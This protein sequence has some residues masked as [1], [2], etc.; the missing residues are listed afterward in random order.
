VVMTSIETTRSCFGPHPSPS[1]RGAGG[2]VISLVKPEIM[3]SLAGIWIILFG[4]S[5]MAMAQ[6]NQNPGPQLYPVS[7]SLLQLKSI[8]HWKMETGWKIYSR[9]TDMVYDAGNHLIG[10]ATQLRSDNTWK[11]YRQYTAAWDGN[12]RLTYELNQI[13]QGAVTLENYKQRLISYD[14]THNSKQEIFQIWSNGV[15]YNQ[16]QITTTYD[17]NQ[18]PAGEIHQSWDGYWVN[19]WKYTRTYDVNNHMTAE[20]EQYGYGA[21][22][23]NS[24]RTTYVYDASNKLTSGLFEGWI[25][26][27]WESQMRFIYTYD[28]QNY[29]IQELAQD[30]YKNAWQNSY[31]NT[32][33]YDTS[34]KRTNQVTRIWNGSSWYN[35]AQAITVRDADHLVI[36]ESHKNWIYPANGSPVQVQGDSTNIKYHKVLTGMSDPAEGNIA[37]Y[38]N[39]NDGIFIVRCDDFVHSLEIFNISGERMYTGLKLSLRSGKEI[40]ITHLPKGVYI[41]RFYSGAKV[42]SRKVVIQ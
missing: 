38:P 23:V 37:V 26:D 10:Y 14:A 6:S 25:N 3:K 11:K 5:M 16:E 33:T 42:H 22:W 28:G 39:P 35:S 18:N 9:D 36:I 40:N 19:K 31:Q 15:W 34:R 8:N 13:W 24:G 7:D 27:T 17:G 4:F 32:F 2:E 20:L 12:N 30:F 1:W 41:L 21:A 29:L